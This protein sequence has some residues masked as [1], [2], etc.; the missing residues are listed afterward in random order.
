MTVKKALRILLSPLVFV[1]TMASL[2]IFPIGLLCFFFS[3]GQG[4]SNLL[5][6]KPGEPV[7]LEI[8]F[9]IVTLPWD[10]VKQFVN[11]GDMFLK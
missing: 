7:D 10:A 6:D 4:I 1:F 5:K 11:T 2:I 3:V 9:A 8:M